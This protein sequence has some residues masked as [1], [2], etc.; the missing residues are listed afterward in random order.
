MEAVTMAPIRLARLPDRTPVRIA[1][2][3]SPELARSLQDYAEVYAK[4]YGQTEP[5]GELIPAMLGAFLDGDREFARL[6]KSRKA[7]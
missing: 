6:R 4:A 2:L 7:E 3:L 1:L 5:L